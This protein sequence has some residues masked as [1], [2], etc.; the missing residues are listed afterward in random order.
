MPT[1]IDHVIILVDD[2]DRGIEQYRKL[3]F[4]VTPGGKHPRYTHNALVTFADGSYLELIAFYE[5]PASTNPNEGHRWF[6]HVGKGGGII[7]YALAAPNLDAL[8]AD[9]DTRDFTH[10]AASPGA[11]KRLDGV[12]IAWKSAM[13]KGDPNVGG[14]P[15]LIEDVTDRGLRVPSESSTHDNTVR[16][17]RSLVVA[18]QDLDAAVTRYCT[19]LEREKPSGEGLP[20]LDNA[21]GVYFMVGEHRIDLATPN[22]DG[23][24]AE[25]LRA[26]GDSPYELSLLAR[27]TRDIDPAQ[28]G[29][30]RLRFV[31]G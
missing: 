29:N 23:P 14:L 27:E 4:T 13:A 28:A 31:A 26:R 8:V 15:F 18:V 25:H 7:D 11:R 19:L 30:A 5:Q 3:G 1:G 16:G 24:L 9:A 2:L 12:E 17:I 10:G 22:G 6:K 21:D 20:N